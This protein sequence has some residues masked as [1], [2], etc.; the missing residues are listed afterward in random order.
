TIYSDTPEVRSLGKGT[1]NLR[2]E[3]IDLVIQPKPKKGQIGGSSPVTLTGPLNRP[4]VRK[5]PF[6]EAARLFGEI[7]MPYAF[8]PARALG[9]VWYLMKNDKDEES[10][11][12]R[13][14]E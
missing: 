8:L 4:S 2:D 12:L 6:I 13:V 14:D 9:Y 11:C 3:T 10:P 5:L 7:F 1:V